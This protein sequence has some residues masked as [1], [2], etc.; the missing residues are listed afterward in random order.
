MKKYSMVE[1]VGCHLEKKNIAWYEK[2]LNIK[3]F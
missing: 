1:M 2:P 3:L